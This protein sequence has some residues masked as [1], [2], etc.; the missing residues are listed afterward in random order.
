MAEHVLQ[1]STRLAERGWPV[2]AAASPSNVIRPALAH[3]GIA[4]HELPLVRDPS[5]HDLRAALRLAALDRERGY[6]IV[7]AHSSK[8]GALVRTALPRSQ[9]LA[10]TPHCFAFAG[11]ARRFTKLVYRGVEQA[12]ASRTGAI[13]A[14][15]EW[16]RR[17]AVGSLRGARRLTRLIRN[18]IPEPPAIAPDPELL[19]F[20]AGE[21]LAGMVTVLRPQKDPLTAV[22]AFSLMARG[23]HGAGRLAIVGNG[24]LAAAIGAEAERL[25][26]GDRVR[27]FGFRGPSARY[28]RAIDVLVSPS[29]WEALPYAPIEALACGVPVVATAVG[30]VP[31]IV[32]HG[33]TGLLV[34]P[35]APGALA[36]AVSRLLGDRRLREDMGR[37]GRAVALERF[38]VERMVDQI[39][40]LYAELLSRGPRGHRHG[41]DAAG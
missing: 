1:L 13:V 27:L 6:A 10:Y 8:A 7:H 15:S 14:V 23:G 4:T 33:K 37:R 24:E 28:L 20:K 12:L 32:D 35:A 30:G 3:A 16:E 29:L 25:A 9:R 18:G 38:G 2:E 19:E 26:L 31:E 36:A 41:S 34:P 21:P 39:E 22:R 5:V 17:Q 40:A 11:G